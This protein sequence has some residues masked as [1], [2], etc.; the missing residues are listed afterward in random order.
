MYLI[1]NSLLTMI[2]FTGKEEPPLEYL[3]AFEEGLRN[4][5]TDIH[6]LGSHPCRSRK[7]W[8]QIAL[9]RKREAYIALGRYLLGRKPD[10]RQWDC[11]LFV[12]YQDRQALAKTYVARHHPLSNG[13]DEENFHGKLCFDWDAH[14]YAPAK[15]RP[16]ASDDAEGV[17][18]KRIKV[19]TTCVKS[20]KRPTMIYDVEKGCL[21]PFE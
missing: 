11:F 7:Y 9:W 5:S 1:A 13:H 16:S 3:V 6:A 12:D 19:E 2:F 4:Y 10:Y 17:G 15:R 18:K 20:T 14:Y 21:V 8:A